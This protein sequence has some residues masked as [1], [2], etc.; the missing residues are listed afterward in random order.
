[1]IEKDDLDKIRITIRFGIDSLEAEELC[2]QAELD[3]DC[4]SPAELERLLEEKLG[5]P[6]YRWFPY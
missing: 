5:S 6:A 3:Y 1:M 4:L 2:R